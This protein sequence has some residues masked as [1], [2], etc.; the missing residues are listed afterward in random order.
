M[1]KELHDLAM[2]IKASGGAKNPWAVANAILNRKKSKKKRA[3]DDHRTAALKLIA[4]KGH[5]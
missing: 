2:K 3:S 4:K 5:A 1:P